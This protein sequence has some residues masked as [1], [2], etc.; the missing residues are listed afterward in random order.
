[1]DIREAMAAPEME[2][3]E[4]DDG[5]PTHEAKV[6]KNKVER[7]RVFAQLK[8]LGIARIVLEFSGSGDDGNIDGVSLF[9]HGDDEPMEDKE[10]DKL[11]LSLPAK[12][13][14]FA[15][16]KGWEV[17]NS[18]G[19]VSVPD[20]ILVLFETVDEEADIDWSNNDGGFGKLTV[21]VE[22][23]TIEV[24]YHQYEQT[25]NHVADYKVH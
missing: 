16:S 1:M 10:A 13:L 20:A 15:D 25:S 9:T 7:E 3:E 2:G 5:T 14:V 11:T 22:A 21:D 18:I 4:M 12:S 6:F 17:H 24:E 19:Q 23:G 8:T